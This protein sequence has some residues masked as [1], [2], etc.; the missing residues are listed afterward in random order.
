MSNILRDY[1]ITETEWSF[2]IPWISEVLNELVQITERWQMP[3]IFT[4]G[5]P[6]QVGSPYTGL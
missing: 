1:K 2:I 3:F 4:Q 5:H 6:C